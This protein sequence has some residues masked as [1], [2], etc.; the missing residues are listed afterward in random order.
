MWTQIFDLYFPAP[1]AVLK[2]GE[3]KINE[4][5]AKWVDVWRVLVDRELSFPLDSIGIQV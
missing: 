1:D 5:R 2:K 4:G 3:E